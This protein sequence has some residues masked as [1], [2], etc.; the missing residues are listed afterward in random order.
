MYWTEKETVPL[1]GS[2]GENCEELGGIPVTQPVGKVHNREHLD[3]LLIEL[4]KLGKRAIGK[5]SPKQFLQ[6]KSVS[7]PRVRAGHTKV[8]RRL[9]APRGI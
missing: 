8:Q 1:G 6:A 5:V 2:T 4:I 9:D 3:L 7:G